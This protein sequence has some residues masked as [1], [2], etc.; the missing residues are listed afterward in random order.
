MMQTRL[1]FAAR[2]ATIGAAVAALTSPTFAQKKYD[3]GATDKEIK[4]GGISPY[5]GPASAYGAIGKAIGA[6]FDKVNAEGG[7]NGRK[8]KWISLDDGY[9]P[10]KTVEQARRLVEED[11]VLF[12]FNTLGTPPNSAIHKYMNAKKVPQLFVATGATKWGDP[13]NF[14]W[15]MGWQPDYQ[16]EAKVFAA[17]LLDTKPNAKVA[18]LYQND[19]YGKDYVKGFEDGLGDKA[20]TMILSKLTYEVTDPTVDSQ[21][22]TLKATGADTFFNVTTPKFAAMVI[23][24]NA[25]IGWKPIHYLNSVSASVGAVMVPAGPE[26]GVGIFTA[27]YLKDPTDPQFQKGKEWD[28][29]LAWMK[30]YH[31]SGDLKDANNVYGYTAA[32]GLMQVLKQAGDNL[33]RE[34][35]MKQAATLDISLPMLLP[36]V[37]VKTGPDDFYPIERE[38]LSKFDGKTWILFGKVYGR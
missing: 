29:W 21:L 15:T 23:K 26:N 18:I 12:I 8:L 9:N 16:S 13:K 20:K 2:W 24:K 36:G 11:E 14:P 17:H 19:D 25:D 28:D 4:I 10:A 7:I 6:Y 1:K 35:I 33:T 5:S 30:K 22:L 32:Q 37:N 3:T 31:P 27:S 34:N 38:Q